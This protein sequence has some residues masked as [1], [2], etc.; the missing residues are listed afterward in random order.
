MAQ[1]ATLHSIPTGYDEAVAGFAP[2]T[3]D[4]IAAQTDAGSFSRG[5]GYFRS[6]HIFGPMRRGNILRARCHGSS[7]EPYVV[8]ATLAAA[9]QARGNNP[10][11]FSC[12]CPRGGF[13]KHVVALL[14]TWVD[15]PHSFEVRPPVAELLAGKSREE[16]V[17]MIELLLRD[18]PD[19]EQLLE[20]P[21]PVSGPLSDEPVDEAAIRRQIEA[22]FRD[23]GSYDEDRYD[24]DRYDYHG[25]GGHDEEGSREGA[26]VARNLEPLADLI[27][28]YAAAGYWR[29]ALT[30]DATFVEEVAPRLE[31]V[32]D[33]GG[34]LDALLARA[35][36][37]LAECL[38]AQSALPDEQRLSAAERKRLIDAILTIW[39][40]D[41]DAGGLDV[42][43]VG[44]EAIARD[45]FPE[46]QRAIGEWLRKS[47][48]SASGKNAA[49]AW[50]QRARIGFLSLLQ[51]DAGLSDEE[52]L[53]EYRSAELWDDAARL[54]FQMG[55]GDEAIALA[56]RH[57]TAA[58][59]LI[60]F[61]DQLIATGDPRRVEQA[62]TLV[63]DRLWEH[64]GEDPSADECV[65]AWLQRQ[66]AEHGRPENA[67]EMARARFDAAPGKQT[68]DA[69][70]SAALLPGQPDDPW[71]VLGPKLLAILRKRGDWAVLIDIFL[72]EGEV[73]KAVEALKAGETARRDRTAGWG[74]GWAVVLPHHYT[75]VAAAAETAFPDEAIAIY[76]RLADEK[77]AARQR[78]AYQEAATYLARIRHVFEA[79]DRAEEWPSLI[80]E[81][82]QQFKNLRALREELDAL[83]LA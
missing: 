44:P 28:A 57:L 78:S 6:H 20:L 58:N 82:R 11:Y 70:K 79:A 61:A 81:L 60:S 12:T 33:E 1:T 51:G 21:L 3:D 5:K 7:G 8:E 19:F 64:E 38:S 15:A 4:M 13:C 72:E 49:T 26:E 52:L 83:G 77:I 62:M 48:K 31:F 29:N 18:H 56:R 22:A 36:T 43:V 41:L 10:L 35:D 40:V 80:A 45:G 25:Y 17:A 73:A 63:D 71:P 66:Y 34:D 24:E 9:D 16:L 74:Y 67:L 50:Q 14:L 68:Y 55:R 59:A 30:V 54:L 42:S 46:E 32:E 27:D 65:R 23:H 2:L 47:L 76:R 39:Q 53:N 69:V 75:R 37:R